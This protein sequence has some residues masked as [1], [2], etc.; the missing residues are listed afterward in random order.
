MISVEKLLKRVAQA[1]VDDEFVL[2]DRSFH[3]NSLN[4]G[5]SA[6]AMVQPQITSQTKDINLVAGQWKVNLPADGFKLLSVNH[7]GGYG[8]EPV[9]LEQ[10]NHLHPTGVGRQMNDLKTGS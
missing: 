7:C 3:I 10:L 8:I 6:I 9:G 4:D 1:L 2:F 5:L